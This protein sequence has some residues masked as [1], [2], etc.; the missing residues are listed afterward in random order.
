MAPLVRHLLLRTEQPVNVEFSLSADVNLPIGHGWHREFD[1]IP[2]RVTIIRGQGAVP[3]FVPEI[4][5]VVCVKNSRARADRSVI[6]SAV[7]VRVNY[8][9]NTVGVPIRGNR[10]SGTRKRKRSCSR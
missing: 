10:R 2:R 8:P 6:A 7:R 1:R 4:R 3:E 9:D 5:S